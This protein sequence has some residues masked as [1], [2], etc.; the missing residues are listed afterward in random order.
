MDFFG[1][2]VKRRKRRL[3]FVKKLVLIILLGLVGCFG[4]YLYKLHSLA[5]IGN[6]IYEERCLAVNPSLTSYKK[7]FLS[8]AEALKNPGKYTPEET[9]DFFNDYLA[10]MRGYYPK[11]EEWLKKQKAF[12]G[13]WDFKLIEPWYVKEAGKY[14]IFMYEGYRDEAQIAIDYLDKK[15]SDDE[16]YQRF[17]EAR[18]RKSKYIDLYY[19]VFDK[20]L[21]IR[22]WRKIFG[23][24]PLPAG[25]NDDNLVIPDTSGALD[26]EPSPIPKNDWGT[27]G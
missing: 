3:G 6:K 14:Q 24:V 25:C 16:F 5:L 9:T 7:S 13:R 10:G 20:A 1:K 15:I 22:D 27:T 11:E 4:L 12:I 8:F 23:S 18:Q 26:P 17:T 2:A 21:P 19:C